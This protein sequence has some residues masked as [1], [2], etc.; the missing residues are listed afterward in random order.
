MKDSTKASEL[1]RLFATLEQQIQEDQLLEGEEW[2]LVS[3]VWWTRVVGTFVTDETDNE[4]DDSDDALPQGHTDLQVHNA[5]LLD[6]NRSSRTRHVTVLKPMLLEGPDYRLVSQRVWNQLSD[7]FSFDWEIPRPVVT[8]EPAK[9]RV[10]EVYPVIFEVLAWSMDCEYPVA[11]KDDEDK[12]WIVSAPTTC[13]VTDLQQHLWRVARTFPLCKSFLE[14]TNETGKTAVQVCYRRHHDAIWTPLERAF[15]MPGTSLHGSMAT[16]GERHGTSHGRLADFQLESRGNEYLYQ[17]LL[18]SRF[19]SKSS[20]VD[21]RH[22]RFYSDIQA[23]TWRFTL[24]KGQLLDALD[25]DKKW[26]ESRVVEL[27]KGAIKVHYRGWTSKWDEW[28]DRMSPRLAPLYTNVPRWREFQRG[29]HVLV[30]KNVVSKTFPEWRVAQVTSVTKGMANTSLQIELEVDGMTQCMDA[31]DELLCPVGTHKAVNGSRFVTSPVAVSPFASVDDQ[32]ERHKVM[33]RG[34]PEFAGVVGLTNLGN[35]CFLNSMLQCLI[36]TAPL[37][38]YFL[39]KDTKTG[40]LFF[41]TELNRT[42]PLGMK[43]MMAVV[44]ATLVRKM[45]SQEYT[46]VTPRKFKAIIG[47][48]APQFA[49]YQQHDSQELMNFVLDGLHEDLNRV[50][51]KP[52]TTLVEHNGRSDA[53]VANDAWHQYLRRNDSVIVDNFMGQLRS[54]V[55]CSNP[56]CGHESI[57]FDPFMSLSVPIPAYE[58]KTIQVQLYWANGNLPTKYAM[59]LLK[60][61]TRLENVVEKL[62][63]FSGIP[64][65]RIFVVEV[66]NHRIHRAYSHTLAIEKL[67]ENVLHA[68]EL[69]LAVTDYVFAS[70]TICPP[71]SVLRNEKDY[72]KRMY[73][74]ELVH[75]APVGSSPVDG[76]TCI[77]SSSIVEL[78]RYESKQRRV[79]VELFNTPLLV[80]I[81]PTWTKA[82]IH[83]KVWQVVHRLVATRGTEKK[84]LNVPYRLHVT[85]ATNEGVTYFEDLSREHEFVDVTGNQ[86]RPFSLTLEWHRH[87]YHR[88]YDETLAKR[89]ELH[90]SMKSLTLATPFKALTLFDCLLKFTER[91]QLGDTDTWY[92]PKCKTHVCAFKKFDLFSLPKV[93]VFHLK[94]FRY[95]QNSFYLHRDKISTFIDFPIEGL[96][97]KDFVVGPGKGTVPVYD[98]YA[99]SEHMGGLG[100]GHYTAVVKNPVH[101]RWFAFND[102]HTS[103]TSAQAAVSSKAYVLFY[104]RRETLSGSSNERVETSE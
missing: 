62:S 36:N 50:H 1:R 8:R 55:T 98:L 34:R 69:E 21:W 41:S 70:P 4:V 49:G 72:L 33:G 94:R 93:L 22:G 84:D 96:D 95:A 39:Q 77:E 11:I 65:S 57:T 54:H 25:T 56:T 88:S 24:E 51:S 75:Q 52:S 14:T 78:A 16:L 74:V 48:Y 28:L 53:D 68:Y 73:L 90:E 30:G 79:D 37:R 80:S 85:A 59:T 100:G 7:H 3:T 32:F 82:L 67:R 87:G 76:R 38:A 9:T 91:E 17:L 15:V 101:L 5:V 26:Y 29:D 46:T 10:I 42:N 6:T 102:S 2:Y 63:T 71:T 45:W 92:C 12:P 104:L 44:F 97:L 20:E 58:T 60:Y 31:Q 35:T 81:D 13:L 89:I 18:E 61:E 19:M 43:G 27:Q 47:Q 99:V 86:T 40:H 103:V 64:T 66:R 23:N 83:E